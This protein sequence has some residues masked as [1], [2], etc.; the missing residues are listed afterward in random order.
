MGEPGRHYVKGTT[1]NTR[2]TYLRVPLDEKF[3]ISKSRDRT[4][5][6]GRQGR[7]TAGNADRHGFLVGGDENVLKSMVERGVQHWTKIAEMDI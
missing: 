5:L 1:P 7:G 4:C 6:G 3:R 2:A